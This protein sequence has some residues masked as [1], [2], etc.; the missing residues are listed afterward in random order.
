MK[1]IIEEEWGIKLPRMYEMGF[2]HANCGGRCVRGGFQHY[3]QLYKIWPDR[4]ALQEEME[5]N[6][7]KN[8]EKNVSILKKDGGPYTLREYRERMDREGIE[9]FLK[10]QDET[11]PCV[12]SFS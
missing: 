9:G 12:C 1:T 11:V 7:R 6:F 10:I 4:Y 3:A 5:E 8:F 2:S